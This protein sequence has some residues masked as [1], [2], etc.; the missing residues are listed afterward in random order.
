MPVLAPLSP[1]LATLWETTMK[2]YLAAFAVCGLFAT[3]VL[4]ANAAVDSA[5]KTFDAVGND[6]AKLK[7]YCEMSKVMSSADAEDDSKSE[8]LD[9][10]MDGFMKDL[11]PEFQ[12]AFEAGADLDPESADGKTYDAAMDKLDDKCGK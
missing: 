12:T 11:G 5:V 8:A 3:P 10:Q 2:K 6:A 9:K 7:V 4:A 1:L